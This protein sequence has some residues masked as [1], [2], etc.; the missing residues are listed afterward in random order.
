MPGQLEVYVESGVR[1]ESTYNSAIFGGMGGKADMTRWIMRE[2]TRRRPSG[3]EL[4]P[5]F[6]EEMENE[7]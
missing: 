1:Y 6:D 5:L 2:W 3:H 7:L 4:R